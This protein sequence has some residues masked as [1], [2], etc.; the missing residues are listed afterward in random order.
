M[1]ASLLL[2][3]V[4]ASHAQDTLA[5]RSVRQQN[6]KQSLVLE[7]NRL[8]HLPASIRYALS[9][10]N[11]EGWEIEDAYESVVT[12]PQTPNSSGLLIY[13]INL[14]RKDERVTIKFDEEGKRLDD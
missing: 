12:D 5:G 9:T 1:V 3:G 8:R 10:P 14:R 6:Q 11:Y 4:T 2:F 13:I 7:K